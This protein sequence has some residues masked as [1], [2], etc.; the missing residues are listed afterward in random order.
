MRYTLKEMVDVILSSMD[1]DEVNSIGDTTESNQVALLVKTV[2]Y[3]I[4]SQLDLPEHNTK[5]ELIPS[6]AAARP[7]IMT[8]PTNC[9][10]LEDVKYDMKT[11]E[12]T[13]SH[14]EPVSFVDFDTFLVRQQ[15]LT[16]QTTG[17]GNMEVTFNND[18]ISMMYYTDRFPSCYTVVE[19]STLIFDAY[20]STIDTTLQS[21]KTLAT[22]W[23]YPE[24]TLSDTF[25]PKLDPTQFSYLLNK[26]KVRAFAELKQTE[27]REASTE[28]R[29][30]HIQ[31]QKN[32]RRTP[33]YPEVTKH[34]SRYGRK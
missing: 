6:G 16:E 30:Q 20:D 21:N 24:F 33:H 17:V 25:T 9:A 26:A 23:I 15:S 14:Y 8:L 1:S 18:T 10:R 2:Y 5:I 29:R 7:T 22:G 11:K 3:D 32:E 13:Y 19:D 4:A 27:N 31:V 12:E 28:S 34:N